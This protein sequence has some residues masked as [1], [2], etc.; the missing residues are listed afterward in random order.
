ME[1]AKHSGRSS[2]DLLLDPGSVQPT[3]CAEVSVL[4]VMP[5]L[6]SS[7]ERCKGGFKLLQAGSSV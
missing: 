5:A 6:A 7:P 1:K 4:L 3:L 2:N